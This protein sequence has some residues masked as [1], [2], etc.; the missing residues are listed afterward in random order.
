M[1]PKFN[2]QNRIQQGIIPSFYIVESKNDESKNN[3]MRDIESKEDEPTLNIRNN[4]LLDRRR[5]LM[6]DK[7]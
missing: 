5:A 3:E 4:L 2:Y 7:E 1:P 6:R